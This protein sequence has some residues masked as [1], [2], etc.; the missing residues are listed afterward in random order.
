MNYT[1]SSSQQIFTVA[2]TSRYGLLRWEL[3]K[4]NQVQGSASHSPQYL[5]VKSRRQG[6]TYEKANNNLISTGHCEHGEA[7]KAVPYPQ[8]HPW[9]KIQKPTHNHTIEVC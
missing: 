1:S 3:G 5:T 4:Y 7:E 6:K 9:K 2:T 8:Q